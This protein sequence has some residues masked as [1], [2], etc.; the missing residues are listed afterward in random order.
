[1][2]FSVGLV[3]IFISCALSAPTA[4]VPTAGV[5]NVDS[6]G[7]RAVMDGTAC[8]NEVGA[9]SGAKA[10]MLNCVTGTDGASTPTQKVRAE[11]TDR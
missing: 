9:A 4:D 5:C 10:S 2:R 7:C 1:M 11:F 6:E 3:A 8:F